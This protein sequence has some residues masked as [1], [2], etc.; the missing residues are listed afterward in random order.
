MSHGCYNSVRPGDIQRNCELT[1]MCPE[2]GPCAG[3]LCCLDGVSL[4]GSHPLG[5]GDG[6]SS[7]LTQGQ[8]MYFKNCVHWLSSQLCLSFHM[9][10]ARFR[11]NTHRL[12]PVKMKVPAPTDLKYRIF[13][14]TSFVVAKNK[15]RNTINACQ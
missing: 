4:L 11:T 13:I 15:S 9:E 12:Y 6:R 10:D 3:L 14:A 8:L 7:L 2:A 5:H 1:R